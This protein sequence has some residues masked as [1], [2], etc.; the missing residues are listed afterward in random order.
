MYF[1][2]AEVSSAARSRYFRHNRLLSGDGRIFYCIYLIYFVRILCVVGRVC[3][4]LSTLLSSLS[5]SRT[6]VLNRCCEELFCC[7][8]LWCFVSLLRVFFEIK[9]VLIRKKSIKLFIHQKF[10]HKLTV[11]LIIGTFSI[12]IFL[13]GILLHLLIQS[14]F[15]R[16]LNLKS[17]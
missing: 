2:C 3:P 9:N 13:K 7:A 8:K 1:T 5:L 12:Y 15:N 11:H 10:Q 6:V 17:L 16:D 14:R 4:S